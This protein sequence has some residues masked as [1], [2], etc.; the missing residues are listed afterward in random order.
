MADLREKVK[1][2]A[3]GIYGKVKEARSSMV[4][5]AQAMQKPHSLKNVRE[6]Q[7]PGFYQADIGERTY[8]GEDGGDVSVAKPQPVERS[9]TYK[10]PGGDVNV[11]K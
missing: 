4:E 11:N 7:G 1:D 6:R 5:T 10:G 9:R 2:Y 8:R 3:K